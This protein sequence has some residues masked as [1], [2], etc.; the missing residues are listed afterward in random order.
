M[1]AQISHRNQLFTDFFR[2]GAAYL[3]ASFDSYQTPSATLPPPVATGTISSGRTTLAATAPDVERAS[4]LY[5]SILAHLNQQWYDP[6][7]PNEALVLE[8]PNRQ[9]GERLYEITVNPPEG[10]II[11][12]ISREE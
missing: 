2:E 8:I 12:G 1:T 10:G 7:H 4:T 9:L 6:E 5:C 3:L 11:I